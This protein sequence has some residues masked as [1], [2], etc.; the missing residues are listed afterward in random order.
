MSVRTTRILLAIGL[1]AMA[2]CSAEPRA[3]TAKSAPRVIPG[4]AATP[5]RSPDVYRVRFETSK[6]PF[7]IE[8][9]RALSPRG[10]D[11]FYELVTIGYYAG[12][13][14]FRMV[15]GFVVQFGI[16]GDPAVNAKW[17]QAA[18]ADEPMRQSNTRGTV[19]FTT[20]DA[21]S[22]TVQLFV[23]M[24]DNAAK[25]DRQRVFAPIG[26]VIEGMDVLERLNVEYGEDPVQSRIMSRGNKYLDRWFPALDSIVSATVVPTPSVPAQ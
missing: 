25:L 13:R 10:A 11:R 22:R 20:V 21:N 8:V 16:H 26:V 9:T 6:G 14:F 17:A 2:A 3:P 4:P 7:A 5:M 23:N 12:N 1:T 15:P 24:A 19:A 18:M